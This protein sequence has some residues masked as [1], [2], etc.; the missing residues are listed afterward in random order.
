MSIRVLASSSSGNCSVV[1][2]SRGGGGAGG[3]VAVPG[4]CGV[5]APAD[6]AV[7]G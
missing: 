7:D 1:T 3:A 5:V 2:V 4:G 6:A